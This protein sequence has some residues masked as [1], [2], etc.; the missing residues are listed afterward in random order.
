MGGKHQIHSG[1]VFELLLLSCVQ[2]FVAPWT[3][4][5]QAPMSMGFPR[6]ENWNGLPF[7][8]PGGLSKPTSPTL[9]GKFFIAEPPGK[10]WSLS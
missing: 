3:V 8:S 2:L 7:L 1:L 9:A 10:P 5:Y 4:A 6:Q